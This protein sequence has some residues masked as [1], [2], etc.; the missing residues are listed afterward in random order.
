MK[1]RGGGRGGGSRGSPSPASAYPSVCALL[2]VCWASPS[3]YPAVSVT[4]QGRPS[5]AAAPPPHSSARPHWSSE[6]RSATL[7]PEEKKYR[8]R[9]SQTPLHWTNGVFMISPPSSGVYS[10]LWP[11]HSPA[12]EVCWMS[13]PAFAAPLWCSS[14]LAAS[15]PAGLSLTPRFSLGQS[16]YLSYHRWTAASAAPSHAAQ[17]EGTHSVGTTSSRLLMASNENESGPS[18]YHNLADCLLLLLQPLC[19]VT[20]KALKLQSWEGWSVITL[21]LQIRR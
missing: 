11:V 1:A 7:V 15:S 6:W 18:P 10:Q 19:D 8:K 5:P 14:V 4:G 9:L 13:P 12:L 3:P 16:S 17:P 21:Q 2:C 20:V